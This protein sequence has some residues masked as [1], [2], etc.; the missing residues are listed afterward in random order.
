MAA[1]HKVHFYFL[2][3]EFLLKERN[4]LKE[5][6]ITIFNK[7]KKKLESIGFI[8]TT[9]RNLYE[10]N[11]EFL[12]H[13]YLTDIL[14]FDLSESDAISSE[15]YIS[16]E[17]VRENAITLNVSFTEELHRVIF[18]GVLHMCGYMDKTRLQKNKMREKENYYLSL[19]FQ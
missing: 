16:V 17:R 3:T 1:N 7:E 5:F 19:Y 18:H 10:M 11:K 15:V 12:S 2:E 8:F 13:D 4:R 9:D 6:I 14:T